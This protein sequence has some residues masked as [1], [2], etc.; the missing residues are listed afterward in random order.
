MGSH[1]LFLWGD[2]EYVRRFAPTT[3][4]QNA[5]GFEICAPLSQKGIGNAPGAWRVLKDKNREHYTW[6]F[7]RYWST[8]RL[9][10][11][12][13]YNPDTA[14]EIWLRDIRRRFGA[15]AAP[16][17]AEA[18]RKAS[19]VVPTIQGQATADYNMYTWPEKDMGGPIN[20]Y[21]HYISFEEDRISS[22]MEHVDRLLQNKFSAKRNP[23]D[24]A[25]RLE[26]LSDACEDA[27]AQAAKV[28]DGTNKEF[29]STQKDFQLISGM[30][31]YFSRKIRA[32]YNLGLYYALSDL[33]LLKKATA[34]AEEGLELWKK[35]S[36]VADE[37]YYD[38]LVMGPGSYGHWKDNIPFVEDDL[39]Q[40]RHQEE[41]Y[42]IVE[43]FDFGFDFG[44][45]PFNKVTEIYTA[46]HINAY[47]IEHRFQGVFPNSLFN[48]QKGFGWNDEVS[49]RAKQ[50]EQVSKEL[51]RASNKENLNVPGEALLSDFV[52]G[53]DQAV[54][55]INLPQG[56]Y[57]AAVIITDRSDNPVD[58]GPMNVS[59]IERFG[60]RPILKDT[61]VKKGEMI[62]KKFN[63]NMVGSRYNTFRLKFS[64]T[65]GA[66]FIVTGLTFTRIEPHIAHLPL[67]KARP[68]QELTFDATVTLPE[69]ILMP[70]KN[71]LSIARGTT[72]TIDP[73][74]TINGVKFFYSTDGGK[75]YKT[76]DMDSL[77]NKIY[78]ASITGGEVKK[79]ELR[80]F[81]EAWDSIGQT[82]HLPSRTENDEYFLIQVT[83]DQ[84]PP[85][86]THTP[87]SECDPGK[88]IRVSAEVADK[89]GVKEVILYYR[90][91]R[92][93]M[94]YSKVTMIPTGN[95]IYEAT[96]P[97]EIITTEFDLMYYI[98]AVDIFGN[99]IY[100]P[101]WHTT[102]PHIT[103]KVRR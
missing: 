49:L 27:L 96:I 11:R 13:T 30:A 68:G 4:F 59:V 69:Q 1:R 47:T 39:K 9:F 81:I 86:V 82:I 53:N 62:V 45:K 63:F 60:E 95:S 88:A 56:H 50:P 16:H 92:Q 32:A 33:S 54:F 17:M 93:A 66:D 77:G 79:G 46:W 91:T 41:L 25:R 73:P 37:L 76:R 28:V 31:R 29:W 67:D 7:E 97:G 43:N 5:S 72:S 2:P 57:Q 3:T 24:T 48:P 103:V 42:N 94:E 85:L 83:D 89:S 51:W 98:E 78:T 21:L 84:D 35:L 8:Y 90:P 44:P 55:R 52:Q 36:A 61:M 19:R 38:E 12:L 6:E 10:G 64:A 75:T 15:E 80:Y 71:S 40:V 20:F 22:L 58:H 70:V 34:Y 18:Y 26:E 100:F 65:P 74:D 102:D 23:E 99:G 101:D 14:D 87:E